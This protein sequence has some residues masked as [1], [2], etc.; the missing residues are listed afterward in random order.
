M[1]FFIKNGQKNIEGRLN[2][3]KF[4]ELK[5]GDILSV[6]KNEKDLDRFDVLVIDK[7]EY[8]TFFEMIKTEGL[9]N[10]LPDKSDVESGVKDVYYKFYSR[11][12]EKEFGVLAIKIKRV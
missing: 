1:F 11:E 7:K 8:K 2:K 5:V 4:K 12:K 3:G 9:E 6:G 10:V